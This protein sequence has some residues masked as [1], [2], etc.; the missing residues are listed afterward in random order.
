[1]PKALENIRR[2][3]SS[4]YL[5]LNDIA[6]VL[7]ETVDLFESIGR[8]KFRCLV[9]GQDIRAIEG[10]VIPQEPARCWQI[11]ERKSKNVYALR[12]KDI[13]VGLVRP[14]RRNIGLLLSKRNDIVGSPD[15]V[16]TIRIKPGMSEQYPVEWLFSA[17]RSEACR[18]QFWTESGGTSYG[19]LTRDHIRNLLLPVPTT[20]V[21]RVIKEKVETWARHTEEGLKLWDTIG[22]PED[23]K[24]IL[25]SPIFGLGSDVG[26]SEAS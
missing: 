13:V 26:N 2:I 24:P 15:G 20:K 10:T 25:N 9:E 17:L 19:K 12:Y 16:A 1:M 14:E 21:R 5:V 4:K 18:L 11:A 6:D 22:T 23:R 7:D 8:E 3:R